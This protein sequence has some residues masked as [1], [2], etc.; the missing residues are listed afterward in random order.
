MSTELFVFL[1]GLAI[2]WMW[3]HTQEDNR[4]IRYNHSEWT[5]NELEAVAKAEGAM[6]RAQDA[7]HSREDYEACIAWAKERDYRSMYWEMVEGGYDPEINW[8]ELMK[9]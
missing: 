2:G 8:R 7:G 4:W 9:G 1:A 6:S 3:R 5:A